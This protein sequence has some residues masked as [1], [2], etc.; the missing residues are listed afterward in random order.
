MGLD[1]AD[2]EGEAESLYRSAGIDAGTPAPAVWLATEL[3][4]QGCVVGIHALQQP[5]GG[6]LVR[7][8]GQARIYFRHRLPPER[9]DF[10]VA[11][12]L[13]HWALGDRAGE[14]LETEQACDALAAALIAPR[15]AFLKLV[16]KHGARFTL[17]ARA[18]A[19]TESLVALRFGETT[20]EPLALVAPRSVRVRGAAYSWPSEPALREIAA[21]A[22]PGLRKTALL[23][24][25]RRLVLRA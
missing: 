12:E 13:A 24:D 19:T 16:Q 21:R 5:G 7:V 15:R 8:S 25:V 2:I 11:H 14:E 10:V 6:C 3:L 1:S 20:F 4:G 23:D 18:F 22:K 9:R 17:L